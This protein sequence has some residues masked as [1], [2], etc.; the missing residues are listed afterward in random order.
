M[1]APR[2]KFQIGF[3][4]SQMGR[5]IFANR[6]SPLAF[7]LLITFSRQKPTNARS[8]NAPDEPRL[9]FFESSPSQWHLAVQHQDD[10]QQFG[11][12]LCDSGV[13]RPFF[14]RILRCTILG[15]GPPGVSVALDTWRIKRVLGCRRFSCLWVQKQEI[16]GRDDPG[17]RSQEAAS[18]LRGA[19]AA[20]RA[21]RRHLL[22]SCRIR[23]DA[24]YNL[25]GLFPERARAMSAIA[26]AM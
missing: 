5:S 19:S 21:L 22:R 7:V 25:C 18:A 9:K 2:S 26:S 17:V 8:A 14:L 11:A 10:S 4:R 3:L 16:P 24:L 1:E 20:S 15:A 13:P 12:V 6:A 23:A